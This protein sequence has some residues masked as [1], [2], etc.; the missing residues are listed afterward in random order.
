MASTRLGSAGSSREGGGWSLGTGGGWGCSRPSRRHEGYKESGSDQSGELEACF[1][2]PHPP[3]HLVSSHLPLLSA[4]PVLG[5]PCPHLALL[6]SFLCCHSCSELSLEIIL[7]FHL[8]ARKSPM[9][10]SPGTLPG[11]GGSQHTLCPRCPELQ[12]AGEGGWGWALRL[13]EVQSPSLLQP[14]P[15]VITAPLRGLQLGNLGPDRPKQSAQ[16]PQRVC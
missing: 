10:A 8:P 7:S 16:C 11:R 1:A 5:P 14:N 2:I 6:S 15:Q 3:P 9:P 4:F 12:S 13:R